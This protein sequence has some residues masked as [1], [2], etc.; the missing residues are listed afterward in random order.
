MARYARLQPHS[1]TTLAF[2]FFSHALSLRLRADENGISYWYRSDPICTFLFSILVMWSTMGTVREAMHVLM[3]GVPYGTDTDEFM[4][5]LQNIPGVIDVHDLHVW[6][7]VGNKNN[8][9]AHL[10]VESTADTTQVLYAAQKVARSIQCHHTCFQL[11]NVATYDRS[12]EG[13]GCFEPPG[14][15]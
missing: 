10:T 15:P 6:T 7:L 14:S 5:K 9:W 2:S 11:E 8:V 12:V 4:R 3:A 1:L 13:P